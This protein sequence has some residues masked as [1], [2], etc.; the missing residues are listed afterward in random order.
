VD[1]HLRKISGFQGCGIFCMT[2]PA[3]GEVI[4]KTG[5]TDCSSLEIVMLKKVRSSTR[6]MDFVDVRFLKFESRLLLNWSV[7]QPF[8][9][10]HA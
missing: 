4:T 8:K 2:I 10:A 3:S 1:A 7:P 5:F 9:T 6:L